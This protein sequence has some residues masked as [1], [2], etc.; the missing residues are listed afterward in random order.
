MHYSSNMCVDTYQ[1]LITDRPR[2]LRKT[3]STAGR[4]LNVI[5][6]RN[7]LTKLGPLNISNIDKNLIHAH[8]PDHINNILAQLHL[9]TIRKT[10]PVTVRITQ[11]NYR[12]N[13]IAIRHE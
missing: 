12:S 13:S 9:C 5:H 4:I 6:Y 8:T 7:H 2:K 3:I 11:R 1:Y 10:S